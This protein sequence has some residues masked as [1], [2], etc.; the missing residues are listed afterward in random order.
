M[1]PQASFTEETGSPTL[2]ELQEAISNAYPRG[3]EVV[4][5]P[6]CGSECSKKT[7]SVVVQVSKPQCMSNA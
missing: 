7:K 4:V 2:E 6:A 5:V 3:S 1:F